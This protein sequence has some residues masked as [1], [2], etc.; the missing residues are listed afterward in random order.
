MS[1]EQ[2]QEVD[3]AAQNNTISLPAE[4]QT[5]SM[6]PMAKGNKQHTAKYVLKQW[7]NRI[8]HTQ[9]CLECRKAAIMASTAR[10]TVL[11]FAFTLPKQHYVYTLK[12]LLC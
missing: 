10:H 6:S 3:I 1:D 11:P 5:H 7:K 2:Q 12:R 8:S 9:P 4:L